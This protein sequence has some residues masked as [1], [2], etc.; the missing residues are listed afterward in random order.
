MMTNPEPLQPIGTLSGERAI[1]K[2]DSSGV[3]DANLLEADRR[4]AGIALEEFKVLLGER[5]DVVWKLS[6]VEPEIRV[7]EVVQSGVQR[8]AL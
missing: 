4:M 8:P 6:I 2:T 1:V 5:S 7:C 3:K